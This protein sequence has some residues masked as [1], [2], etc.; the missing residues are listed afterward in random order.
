[1]LSL[2]VVLEI[3]RLLDE[4]ELTQREIAVRLGVSRS[5]VCAVASGRR[6]IELGVERPLNPRRNEPKRLPQRCHTCGGL[7]F[8]PCRLCRVRMYRAAYGPRPPGQPV[9]FDGGRRTT[10]AARP[11]APTHG[12]TSRQFAIRGPQA[13]A[14]TELLRDFL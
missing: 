9:G 11:E 3:R 10:R 6:A 2:A 7:V 14:K 8:A 13:E 4:D 12:Q 5:T 1:M